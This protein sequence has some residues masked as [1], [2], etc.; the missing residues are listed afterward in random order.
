MT[1]HFDA[2]CLYTDRERKRKESYGLAAET[3]EE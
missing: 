1:P 2:H 3:Q